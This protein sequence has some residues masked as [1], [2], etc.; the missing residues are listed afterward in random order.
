MS[1]Y[2]WAVKSERVHNSFTNIMFLHAAVYGAVNS[3]WHLSFLFRHCI[4]TKSCECTVQAFFFTVIFYSPR[5]FGEM[6]HVAVKC[7]FMS[8]FVGA[9]F[10]Q[11]HPSAHLLMSLTFA[12]VSQATTPCTGPTWAW[13]GYRGPNVIRRGERTSSLLASV[14]WRASPLTGLLV[15]VKISCFQ[16]SAM[17]CCLKGAILYPS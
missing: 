12:Y 10:W 1:L 15:F 2:N 4:F 3:G 8:L 11:P 17:G 14:G 13:T 7:A 6:G 16:C 5:T 9:A